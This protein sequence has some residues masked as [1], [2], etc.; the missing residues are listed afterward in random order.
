MLKKEGLLDDVFSKMIMKW[1]HNSGFNVHN[2]VLIKPEDE[3]W[4]ENLPQ[5]I[6]R[7][8]FTNAKI[9]YV[10][11]TETVLYRSKMSHGKI[12]II[13]HPIISPITWFVFRENFVL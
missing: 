10:E 8:A 9:Q 3:K 6:I 1:R 2:Q 11:E 5:Y 7:N 4:V 13:Y 12:L